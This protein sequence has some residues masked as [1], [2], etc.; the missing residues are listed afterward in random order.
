MEL[1]HQQSQS[2]QYYVDFTNGARAEAVYNLA[3]SLVQ[4]RTAQVDCA[5]NNTQESMQL[6]VE[7]QGPSGALSSVHFVHLKLMDASSVQLSTNFYWHSNPV[8]K[9]EDLQGIERVTLNAKAGELNNGRI[10]VDLANRSEGVA[11]AARLKVIDV[12]SGLLAA[13]VF[14]SDNYLSLV[15]RESRRVETPLQPLRPGRKLKLL[16][17]GWIVA[18]AELADSLIS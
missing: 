14:Y 10:A 3:G 5:A 9:Y 11:L 8:W 13:P 16:F 17:E 18:P 4:T 15:P 7:G 6:F 1:R 2:D 12:E